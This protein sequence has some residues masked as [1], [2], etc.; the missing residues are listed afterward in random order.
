MLA[1]LINT[2]FFSSVYRK[3]FYF[4]EIK[5]IIPKLNIKICYS[6]LLKTLTLARQYFT[7][8]QMFKL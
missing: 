8:R 4:D 6:I 3:K 2:P 7:Y 5:L 1:L